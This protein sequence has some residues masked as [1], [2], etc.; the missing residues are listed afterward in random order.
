MGTIEVQSNIETLRSRMTS[1]KIDLVSRK[2]K[3]LYQMRVLLNTTGRLCREYEAV[4]ADFCG[5]KTTIETAPRGQIDEDD[6]CSTK[7]KLLQLGGKLTDIRRKQQR[8]AGQV[9]E[10]QMAMK[11]LV[12]PSQLADIEGYEFN[13]ESFKKESSAMPEMPKICATLPSYNLFN[14]A[15]YSPTTS[16]PGSAMSMSSERPFNASDHSV[17]PKT[18]TIKVSVAVDST[19]DEALPADAYLPQRSGGLKSK[20]KKDLGTGR[21]RATSTDVSDTES[22]DCYQVYTNERMT[23]LEAKQ[24]AE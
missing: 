13:M 22:E 10:L 21:R 20:K 3:R 24:K 5:V 19:D 1:S 12:D 15:P 23:P 9:E 8:L 18:R 11:E 2:A 16:R 6:Y 4:M 7:T 14:S 17:P